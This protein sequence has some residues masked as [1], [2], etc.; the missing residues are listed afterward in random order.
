MGEVRWVC[1]SVVEGVCVCSYGMLRQYR[2][3]GLEMSQVVEMHHLCVLQFAVHELAQ[4]GLDELRLTTTRRKTK[5]AKLR[6][7]GDFFVAK[8]SLTSTPFG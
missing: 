5:R 7:F 1:K 6:I 8:I 3:E 2:A 4:W